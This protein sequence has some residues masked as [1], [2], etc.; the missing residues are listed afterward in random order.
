MAYHSGDAEMFQR[1][2]ASRGVEETNFANRAVVVP[3]DVEQIIDA[4]EQ[5][6]PQD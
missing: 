4:I 2:L 6:A 3:N 5:H 1:V